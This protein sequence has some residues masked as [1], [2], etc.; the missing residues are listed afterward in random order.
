MYCN[1]G[2][3]S[4]NPFIFLFLFLSVKAGCTC[5]LL[6][7]HVVPHDS[8]STTHSLPAFQP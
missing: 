4:Q 7:P 6:K 5:S 8:T 1:V 2:I 3:T